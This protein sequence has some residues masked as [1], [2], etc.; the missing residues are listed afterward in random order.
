[1]AEY[2]FNEVKNIFFVGGWGS[3]P[4]RVIQNF[5]YINNENNS[6][7]FINIIIH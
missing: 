5:L 3:K 1:M 7:S 2:T 6:L 4:S